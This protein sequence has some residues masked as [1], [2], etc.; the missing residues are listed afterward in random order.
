LAEPLINKSQAIQEKF[1]GSDNHLVAGAWLTKA[2]ICQAKGF[3][4]EADSLIEKARLSIQK[5]GNDKALAKLE[6][7]IDAIRQTNGGQVRQIKADTSPSTSLGASQP[8]VRLFNS[9]T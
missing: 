9:S 3:S 8:V 4:A 2:K 6:L 1:Y 7:Q 5:T